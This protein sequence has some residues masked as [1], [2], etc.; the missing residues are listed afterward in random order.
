MNAQGIASTCQGCL[1]N[2]SVRINQSVDNNFPAVHVQGNPANAATQGRLCPNITLAIDQLTDPDR[3]LHPL[4][5]TNP[6]KGRHENPGFKR[7]TWDEALGEIADRMIDLRERDES[8]KLAVVKGRSTG[9][10]DLLHKALPEIYGTSNRFTH[11]GICAEA[12]KQAT[13]CLDGCW[14]YHD[15]D[16]EHAECLLLW[17]TDPLASNRQKAH[18]LHAWQDLRSH[19]QIISVSPGLS[20]T[21]KASS[22]WLP[23]TPGTDGALACALAHVILV[24]GLWSRSFVGDFVGGGSF[25]AGE[26]VDEETFFERQTHGLVSWWNLALRHTTPEW[27]TPITGI[28]VDD[29]RH[30]AHTFAAAGPRAASWISPGV[31]MSAR[32]LYG[33]MAC[34]AL[35]GLVG[36]VGEN[37]VVLRFPAAPLLPLPSTTPFQDNV[38]RS[39]LAKPVADQRGSLDLMAAKGGIAGV[40][41]AT[42]RIAD[43]LLDGKPYHLEM[44][45][46]YWTNLPFSCTGAQ[47]WEQTLSQLPFLVHITT[48]PSEMSH[49]ADIVLPAQH[50]LCETWG[51]ANSRQNG[52]TC[53]TLEQPIVLAP[54]EAQGD[55]TDFPFD[56]AQALAARGFPNLKDY[57]ASLADPLTGIQP[58]SGRSLGE[59]AVKLRTQRLWDVNHPA[60]EPGDNAWEPTWDNFQEAGVWSSIKVK[61]AAVETTAPKTA[62][63]NPSDTAAPQPFP[64]PSGAFEFKSTTLRNLLHD[65]AEQHGVT[66]D[67]ALTTLGYQARGSLAYIPHY[68]E[69][70]R[71]GNPRLYPFIF[72][73]HRSRLSLEGR[74][75]NLLHYQQLKDSDPGDEPWDDV[76]KMHS[77][78]M[79][80]CGFSNGDT[81][82]ITSE[83]GSI[84]THVKAWEGTRPG[85]VVKCYGQGHWAYGHIAAANFEQGIP[86]G[87]NN[88]EL[89]PCAWERI[90]AA[91]ARHGGLA[92]VRVEKIAP[93]AWP[94]TT[95]HSAAK[96]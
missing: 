95:K 15:Y 62:T 83:Q 81:V 56:L 28:N 53:I 69:P 40:N 50:H 2:C 94:K 29:I 1:S 72:S 87:G 25:N 47:R 96:L 38:A 20:V 71:V 8:Y 77:T 84:V 3:V 12:E 9:I 67:E 24:E 45:I 11:D 19:A 61:P 36:S 16:L 44:M 80:R 74:S 43:A 35:N 4:R 79:D 93:V 27:A 32:G 68:E 55:E 78:D 76:L 92:R 65:H 90:T 42:N 5:R 64:T 89:I 30:M 63:A 10:A 73:Q 34:Y 85:V 60:F 70:V 54:G 6:H 52:H 51:L 17:G 21:G 31:A 49:F 7:I 41:Q 39:A 22:K 33:G 75:A 37:G 14:D 48:N 57:Y 46:A 88:N 18:A 66:P 23:I 58:T 13:G 86:R 59:V 91:T 82:R 26:L